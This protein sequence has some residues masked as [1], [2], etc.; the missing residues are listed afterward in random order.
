MAEY[1]RFF[2]GVSYGEGDQA[3]VTARAE[4]DGVC[5]GV[6]AELAVTSGGAGFVNVGTGE[7]WVQG[8]WYK[9]DATKVLPISANSSATARVDRIVLRLNRTGNSLTAVVVEG[10]IGAGTPAL[11]QVP[12]GIWELPLATVSTANS[13]SVITDARVWQSNV[14][15]PMTTANDVIIADARGNP[16]RLAKGAN[17]TYLGVDGSGNLN[18]SVPT[19][20][21]NPMTTVDDIIVG[22]ASGAATRRAKGPANSV[23][24][25]NSSGVLGY[26]T[27]ANSFIPANAI[28]P[29]RL[30]SWS[31]A[32]YAN[33]VLYDHGSGISVTKVQDILCAVNSINGDKIITNTL[34]GNKIQTSTIARTQMANRSI[35]DVSAI[36]YTNGTTWGAGAWAYVGGAQGISG[37]TPG[38]SFC[39]ITMTATL[40]CNTVNAL[41]HFGIGVDTTGSPTWYTYAG[42]YAAN[43]IVQM[44]ICMAHLSTAGAHTYYPLA[45]TNSGTLNLYGI[46]Q[47]SVSA[48][49]R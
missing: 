39:I 26:H 23:F 47:T 35:S 3:E 16:I 1:G 36:Q 31:G 7:A 13:I 8:F 24:G 28:H 34:H 2:D 25:V 42:M 21:A 33:H 45:Y 20:F 46:A 15:N 48:I 30:T 12:G 9:N 27:D 44:T 4:R 43:G 41:V 29:N 11:T 38:V 32:T 22:G 14:Y 6:G 40:Q 5:I 10:V 49:H 37:L 17:G 18:Y 19:G